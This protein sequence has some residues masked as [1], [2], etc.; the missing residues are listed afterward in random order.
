MTS[1]Q[2]FPERLPEKNKRRD[3]G[4]F[5]AMLLLLGL[6]LVTLYIISG[7]S[8]LRIKGNEL[9]FVKNQC[10]YCLIGFFLMLVCILFPLKWI[11]KLLPFIVLGTALICLI[12]IIPGIGIKLNGARR[13]IRIPILG[14]FQPSELAKIAVVLYLAHIF[15]KENNK[16][17]GAVVHGAVVLFAFV[18]IIFLQDD[19]STA[20]FILIL[21]L[22]VFFMAGVKIYWFVSFGLMVFPVAFLFIFTKKYRVERLVA[23][24]NPSYDLHGL[25]YQVSRACEVISSGGFW[26]K[27]INGDLR[28]VFT[29]PEVQADFIFAGWAEVMGLFGVLIYFVLLVY[30][31]VKGFAFALNCADKFCGLTVFGLV[32]SIVLQS[33]MNCGVVCGALPST[34]IPLPFFSSGGSSLV[35]TLMMC[36]IIMNIF[37]VDKKMKMEKIYE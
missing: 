8:G 20:F 12:T 7:A 31:A 11:K 16:G 2:V 23:F 35:M 34:G 28:S 33:L 36:G 5:I 30:F 37:R 24:F 13:W 27:G 25:N 22:A 15:S 18:L 1:F 21:G 29:I 14:R 26:G 3:N 32:T 9:H 6:G 19:F 17:A 10:I 4:F